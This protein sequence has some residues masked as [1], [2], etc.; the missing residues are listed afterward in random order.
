MPLKPRRIDPETAGPYVAFLMPFALL[1]PFAGKAYHID[2]PLFLWMAKRIVE[3]PFDP[4][5]LGV[6]WITTTEPMYLVNQNPPGVAYWLALFGLVLGWGEAPL[7]VAT[8]FLAGVAG[9]GTYALA[10]QW[11]GMPLTATLAAVL[12]PGF[13][14]SASTVMSDVPMLALYVGGLAFW[15]RGIG[16]KDHRLLF[17]ACVLIACGTLTKYF[18]VTAVPLTFVYTFV[19]EKRVGPWVFHYVTVIGIIGAY[20]AWGYWQ[21]GL[22]L[23]TFA[24]DFAAR[25]RSWAGLETTRHLL[26]GIAFSGACG[27]SLALLA[28]FLW[29]RRVFMIG[30]AAAV[31]LILAAFVP[32]GGYEKVFSPA[33]LSTTTGYRVQVGLWVAAGIH[34]GA[35]V[36]AEVLKRR[37]AAAAT[38][39]CWAAG[40]LAFS[41]FVNHTVNARTLLPMLPAMGIAAAW[42]IERLG[43][44]AAAGARWL[45]VPLA[46]AGALAG[47]VMIGDYQYANASRSA[48]ERFAAERRQFSERVY[49][50]DHWGFQYYMQEAG[51]RPLEDRWTEH[52]KDFYRPLQMGD[53]LVVPHAAYSLRMPDPARNR[54]AAYYRFP[55]RGWMNTMNAKA[56]AGFYSHYWG[57]LP[58]AIGPAPS[59]DFAFFIVGVSDGTAAR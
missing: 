20:I 8:A 21:Y 43:G 39:L 50:I 30:T 16:R 56:G 35:V 18:A 24:A 28:P 58:F 55:V 47:W 38:V 40:T 48:A 45:P 1:L 53:T 14:V 51:A 29:T 9:L 4:F 59:E 46:A 23:L 5:G 6:N 36:L 22:N 13:L 10:R 3:H 2:D 37:D 19:R 49:F 25:T 27:A 7:H 26:T 52:N 44:A 42:R 41:V 54:L 32:A 33:P 17:A 57:A 31:V 15:V 11:C 12:T 34:L